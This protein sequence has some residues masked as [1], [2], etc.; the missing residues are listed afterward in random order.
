LVFFLFRQI[1]GQLEKIKFD[2]K[3]NDRDANGNL[4]VQA[5]VVLTVTS[6]LHHLLQMKNYHHQKKRKH[7]SAKFN[8]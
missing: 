4:S 6:P 3:K 2:K 5:H 7:N 8:E 1:I